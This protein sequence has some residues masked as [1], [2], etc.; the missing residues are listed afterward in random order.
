MTHTIPTADTTRAPLTWRRG[1]GLRVLADADAE[2][3]YEAALTLLATE[4]VTIPDALAREALLAAGAHEAAGG[5]MTV[6]RDLVEEAAARA[7]HEIV[8]G[9][10]AAAQDLRLA[11][12][13]S[14]LA[15]GGEPAPAAQPADAEDPVRSTARELAAAVT[16]ADAL[17]E[18]AVVAGPPLRA[19][20][21]ERGQRLLT[22]VDVTVR[23][24][25]KHVL[26]T[27]PG[28]APEAEAVVAM[29]AALRDGEDELRD[30]P[31]FSLFAGPGA[32]A[33]AGVF[34]AAGLP[35]GVLAAPAPEACPAFGVDGGPDLTT[36]LVSFVA[37]ALSANAALQALAPGAA[38]FVPVRPALAGVVAT[39]AA[40]Q[41]FTL[42]ASQLAARAGLPAV[43]DVL[44][45]G[46]ET[47]GWEAC[48]DGSFAALTAVLAGV[49]LA[50][51]AGTLAGGR[52]FSQAQLVA[53]AELFSWS[54]TVGRGIPV[55]DDT[56]ALDAIKQVDV[57]G[58]FLGQRHTRRHMKDVWR[59]RL[60]DRSPWEAWVAGGRRDAADNARDLAAGLLAGHEVEPLDDERSA[61]LQRI[62]ATA[63]L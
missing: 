5:A 6:P 40:A 22:E 38:Y 59:P 9:A 47:I 15:A 29:A 31:P 42:A 43:A 4:G 61:I 56:L 11:S 51:G 32:F 18:V 53:D 46:A 60:L 8:L 28:S 62:I 17:P 10:R 12:G 41:L 39:G 63:G 26:L 1:V 57:C 49:P 52:V 20:D 55:D 2:L 13:T 21:V 48:T 24:T 50:C 14:L 54:A 35:G 3:V 33:A 27:T 7:P 58:N 16:L 45:T 19:L 25:M 37:R 23:S 30:R 36:A 34:A 44:R